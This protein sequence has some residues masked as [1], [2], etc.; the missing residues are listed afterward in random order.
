[1]TTLQALI[2]AFLQG[3]TELF[4]V[5]SLGHAVILP[6]LLHWALDERGITFLPF[7]VM[8][9]V[10]TAAALLLYFWRDWLAIGAGVLGLADPLHVR[11]SRHILLLIVV[12]TIPAVVIG[13]AFES[14]LRALFGTPSIAAIFLMLN[15]L[16]LFAGE[17]L[18]GRAAGRADRPIAELT[19]IDAL[20]VGCWQCLAFLPGISRSGATMTGGLLRGI[21]HQA[22]ARF[23]FLIA[24]PVILAATASQ[25]LKLHHA[26]VGFAA[27]QPALLGALVAGITALAST[28]F[29]M[30]YFREHDNWA[31][32]PFAIYSIIAGAGS[33][34]ALRVF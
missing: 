24:L 34:V 8:L 17:R 21:D 9:H 20:I 7:L 3:V 32:S 26:H 13:F 31:L 27:L 11:E 2:I 4:P 29:L 18:R 23:S 14:L 19:I 1:M 6:A 5:S 30:R 12:A 10:G 22:S 25:A 16:M 28:A 15:G 33:F